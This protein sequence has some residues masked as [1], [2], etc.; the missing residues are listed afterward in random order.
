MKIMRGGDNA[1]ANTILTTRRKQDEGGSSV[2]G[3]KK[4][5]VIS[6]TLQSEAVHFPVLSLR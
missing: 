3:I 5:T 6:F 4:V 2:D 1:R